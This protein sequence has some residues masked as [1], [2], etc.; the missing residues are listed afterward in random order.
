MGLAIEAAVFDFAAIQLGDKIAERY[1]DKM[2][3][4][5]KD[6][7]AGRKVAPRIPKPRH[8]TGAESVEETRFR[9]SEMQES[10]WQD[11]THQ[12]TAQ[13]NAP[14]VTLIVK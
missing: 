14:A 9:V 3:L 5:G 11:V 8:N 7:H 13:M 1:L 4:M 10:L 6:P 12:D 2:D